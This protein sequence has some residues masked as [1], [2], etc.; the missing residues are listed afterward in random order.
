MSSG[1]QISPVGP[2]PESSRENGLKRNPFTDSATPS[3]RTNRTGPHQNEISEV[4]SAASNPV[5]KRPFITYRLQ[6]EYPRP[7]LEDKRYNRTRV[8]NWIIWAFVVIG[9]GVSAYINYTAYAKVPKSSVGLSYP[10]FD[11]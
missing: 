3:I 8:G 4:V 7:W 11:Y 2:T 9:L 5:G 10:C 1:H 6:G